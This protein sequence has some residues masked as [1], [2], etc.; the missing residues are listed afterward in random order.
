MWDYYRDE[1]REGRAD[2]IVDYEEDIFDLPNSASPSSTCL[3]ITTGDIWVKSPTTPENV[4]S[5]LYKQDMVYA[6]ECGEERQAQEFFDHFAPVFN[7]TATTELQNEYSMSTSKWKVPDGCMMPSH[8][9]RK[10]GTEEFIVPAYGGI[11]SL[12]RTVGVLNS[13]AERSNGHYIPDGSTGTSDSGN[14]GLPFD[15][16]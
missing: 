3:V 1:E 6:K 7:G 5:K 13:K 8:M 4:F 12:A 15:L 14:G 2:F 16:A 9:W 10:L 11:A